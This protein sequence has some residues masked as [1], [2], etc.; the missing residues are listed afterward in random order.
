MLN[1]HVGAPA[2]PFNARAKHFRSLLLRYLPLNFSTRTFSILSGC[3]AVILL[4][5]SLQLFSSLVMSKILHVANDN[6]AATTALRQQQ[7]TLDRARMALLIAS[8]KLNRAGVYYMEDKE[9][10]SVGSWSSL[11]EEAEVALKESQQAYQQFSGLSSHTP[12]EEQA[13]LDALKASY[14]MFYSGIVEEADSLSKNGNIDA[15]FNVPVQAFQ[16]DFNDKYFQFQSVTQQLSDRLNGGLLTSLQQ[17]KWLSIGTL[18]FLL[19]IGIAVWW[20]VN[21]W[22]IH[23]LKQVNAQLRVMAEGD[24]SDSTRTVTRGSR[25]V[26][27]LAQNMQDMQQGLVKL[28]EDV[29]HASQHI[30]LNIDHLVQGN[31]ELTAQAS[32]QQQALGQARDNLTSLNER[33]KNNVLHARA[34]NNQSEQA[35]DL[36]VTGSE[37]MQK[38]E[39]S[40]KGI[41]SQSAEMSG[42]VEIIKSVAFQTNI[43]ALNATIEAAHAGAQGRGFAVVAREV[44]LLANKSSKSSQDVHQLIQSSAQQIGRGAQSVGQLGDSQQQVLRV[45]AELSALVQEITAESEHQSQSIDDI[46]ERI[47]TLNQVTER[48]YALVNDAASSSAKLS[49]QCQSLQQAIARFHLPA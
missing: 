31:E 15:F 2:T 20:G 19:L 23:P 45:I 32:T 41:V 47:A 8:D 46:A 28:V 17:A 27:Q 48:N 18:G 24:L 14:D 36:A 9:T 4:F 33:V 40:M 1:S 35:R 34:A 12:P 5:S 37:V 29:R 11:L 38:V 10:G 25:E 26:L 3:I 43:L 16:S 44:G 21:K 42:I 49:G 7:M 39:Q 13:V 30:S 22:V 6:S